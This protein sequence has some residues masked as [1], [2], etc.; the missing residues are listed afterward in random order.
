M[1][2]FWSLLLSLVLAVG[3]LPA[4]VFAQEVEQ[5]DDEATPETSTLPAFAWPLRFEDGGNDFVVY[6][7]QFDRWASN[8]LE[9]RAAVA[10]RPESAQEPTFGVV[11]LSAVTQ[12]AAGGEVVIRDITPSRADFPTLDSSSA[13]FLASIQRQLQTRSWQVSEAKLKNDLDIDAAMRR[14]AAEPVRNDVPDIVYSEQPAILVPVDGEPV[15][16]D[17]AGGLKRVVNTRALLLSD[18]ASGRYFLFVSDH[19]MEAPALAGPWTAAMDPPA[20]L[21]Q[22]KESAVAENQVDLLDA[23]EGEEQAPKNPAIYVS[24]TPAELLQT[25]GPPQYSPV[26]NTRLLYVTNTPNRIFLDTATQDHYVL[27]SGRWFRARNLG[28]SSWQHVPATR[29]PADFA[30]IPD[31]H[32][33]QSVRAAVAG[34]PQAREATIENSVPKVATVN[35]NATQLTVDYDGD[36]SFHPVEG[37]SLQRAVNAPIPVIRVSENA[38]YALDNGVWFVAT[39]PF[40]PWSVATSVPAAVYAI[41]RSSPIHYVTYVRVY[42]ATPDYVYVGYT[43]GYVGS[44]VT[45]DLVVVYGSGWHYRPWIGTYWYSAPVTWGFGFTYVHSWWRPWHPWHH[46]HWV[47]VPCYRPAWGPWFYRPAHR[48][49]TVVNNVTV[50]RTQVRRAHVANIYNRWPRRE[51]VRNRN[52]EPP[53]RVAAVSGRGRGMAARPDGS[54]RSIDARRDLDGR[55]AQAERRARTNDELPRI[56]GPNRRW[57]RDNDRRADAL[58]RGTPNDDRRARSGTPP[59]A[60]QGLRSNDDL[61]RIQGPNRR[62]NRDNDRRAGA[63]VPPA[64]SRGVQRNGDMRVQ[65]QNRSW[66]RND[67]ERR[68]DL[69]RLQRERAEAR[70]SVRVTPR[71]QGSAT[72][73][74]PVTRQESARTNPR[75]EWNSQAQRPNRQEAVEPQR[76]GAASAQSRNFSRQERRGASSRPQFQSQAQQPR[77]SAAPTVQARPPSVSSQQ[78]RRSSPPRM[79]RRSEARPRAQAHPRSDGGRRGSGGNF[80]PQMR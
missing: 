80:R 78:A 52:A 22:A 49:V 3:P 60:S 72:P 7:P 37:T 31:S 48:H 46:H 58:Q 25:D 4:G 41:P 18:P 79:E 43:P 5:E 20:G 26:E 69:R 13:N 64:A 19:W 77:R 1:N 36:P 32:P 53:R 73:S 34:T 24:T 61:P 62:W 38:F 9:G 65:G 11:W 56:Q 66:E 12:P 59:D 28:P 70:E 30:R 75:R 76:R 8:R 10:V 33:T 35:R 14:T 42:D 40:G 16:R 71:T 47:H 39:S 15:L 50:N 74:A 29:L 6:Q 44:Y 2:K 68:A 23:D 57:N 17:A 21:E 63:A 67:A 54:R 45:P 27:I 51:V 55:R